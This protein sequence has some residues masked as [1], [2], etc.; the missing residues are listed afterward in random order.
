MDVAVEM[1]GSR[2]VS[3]SPVAGPQEDRLMHLRMLWGEELATA[4]RST[5]FRVDKGPT[6]IAST[7]SKV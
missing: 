2:R 3:G 4:H 7:F 1:G 6:D 5:P